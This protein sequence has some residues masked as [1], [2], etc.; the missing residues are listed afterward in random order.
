MRP[1]R[2][3]AR[4]KPAEKQRMARRLTDRSGFTL[5]EVMAAALVLVVGVLGALAMLD[6]ATL[7]AVATK[8][9]EAASNLTR[10]LVEEVRAVPYGE[11]NDN[12]IVSGLQSQPGLADSNPGGG[13]WS[14][15]RRGTSYTVD[16][17]TCTVDDPK[18]GIGANEGTDFCKV[19]TSS[20][21][22]GSISASGGGSAGSTD[23]K[24]CLSLG[25]TTISTLCGA[26][27]T[28]STTTIGGV[29]GGIGAGG[30]ASVCG[31]ST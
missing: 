7:R 26:L 14:V 16:A 31:S 1:L 28:G 19:D 18:D 27:Q 29:V 24:L 23:V 25:G 2:A 20:G 12:T 17:R 13:G 30:S 4:V 9:R 6:G 5:V 10:E 11:L 15:N 3:R 8:Q 22:A 21:C